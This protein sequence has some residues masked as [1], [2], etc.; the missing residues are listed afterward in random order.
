VP[1]SYIG[2]WWREAVRHFCQIIGLASALVSVGCAVASSK[3]GDGG[4]DQ[5]G[6]AGVSAAETVGAV[7]SQSGLPDTVAY[8]VRAS[9]NK[10][11]LVDQRDRPFLMVGDAPQ[12]IVANLS[13]VEAA[14]YM[15]NRQKYGF[16][17]LWVNLL[18]N[19]SDGC[20][21]DAGTFDGVVPFLATGDLSKPNPLYF[22]RADDMLRLAA[23][24]GMLVLLDPIETSSWLPVLHDAGVEQAFKYGQYLGRRYKG[25]PNIVWMHGND[26]Q[27][28]RSS[29]DSA[30]V[31]AVARGIRSED[32]THIHTIELNFEA[33]GSLDDPSWAPLIELDAA[34]TYYPTYAQVLAEYNRTEFKPVFMV[35]A[36]Y[37]FE[38]GEESSPRSLRHQEYWTMLSG[39]T[40]QVYGS[41]YTWRLE[42]GWETKIDSLGASQLRIMKE[43]FVK[44]RWYE[45][46]PDQDHTV[47]V[48]GY[49]QLAEYIGKLTTYVE[50]LR[51]PFNLAARLRRL[52]RLGLVGRNTFS[53]AARTSDGT[54]IMAYLAATQAVTV[55]MSKLSGPAHARWYDPT[56]GRYIPINGSPFAPIGTH[57]FLPPASNNAGDDDWVL[58]LETDPD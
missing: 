3:S 42:K 57:E 33:S 28:W 22:Q 12:T 41:A 5:L 34:Y 2:P 49:G 27:S 18:C 26:F 43:L 13:V 54:L 32:H 48:D 6:S 46:S 11:Y 56:N 47:V 9:D 45:L 20:R 31:Q 36:N 35:E 52:T 53:P 16:N 30:L 19:F 51:L 50:S 37:E 55:A 23:S 10:R 21:K 58:V 15:S 17:T 40:G 14:T 29:A 1:S 39:A 8:P 25:F 38:R 7:L 44:R 24:F 4:A